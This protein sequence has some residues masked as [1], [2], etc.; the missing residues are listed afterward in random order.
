MSRSLPVVGL[1][2]V[3]LYTGDLNADLSTVARRGLAEQLTPISITTKMPCPAWGISAY[4]CRLGS[5]LA[6]QHGTVCASCYSRKGRFRFGNVQARLE[7]AYRGLFDPLWTPALIHQVRWHADRYFRLFH[8]GDLQGVNHLKNLCIVARNVPDVQFWL[9]TREIETCRAVLRELLA[10]PDNLRVRV[11]ASMID[12]K[13]PKW[14]YTSV[15]TTEEHPGAFGCLSR[16][17]GGSCGD[18]RACWSQE[19]MIAYRKH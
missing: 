16:E 13:P 12:G 17:Q 6:E 15:V 11:S 19:P 2:E 10:F 18:C 7:Q 14:P 8:S 1:P 9:P 5:I 3:P 4:R